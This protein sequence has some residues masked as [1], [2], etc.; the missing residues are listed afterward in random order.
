MLMFIITYMYIHTRYTETF[1]VC[2]VLSVDG[3]VP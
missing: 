2:S 3:G 1:C